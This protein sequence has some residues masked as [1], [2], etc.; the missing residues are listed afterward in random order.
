MG[1]L[2]VLAQGFPG[3][4][5][6]GALAALINTG[7]WRLAFID[8]ELNTLPLEQYVK[9]EFYKN[10]LIAPCRDAMTL[11]DEH[12][13]MKSKGTPKAFRRAYQLV[14]AFEGTDLNGKAQSWGDSRT[15]GPETILGVDG[16]TGMCAAGM[17]RVLYMN[18]KSIRRKQD[19]GMVQSEVVEYT[20]HLITTLP[21]HLY[22]ISHLKINSPRLLEPEDDKGNNPG[23][24]QEIAQALNERAVEVIPT[25]L[26]PNLLGTAEAPNYPG[27]FPVCLYF[28]TDTVH[29]KTSLVIRTV[30]H[31]AVVVKVPGEGLAEKLPVKD[32]LLTIFNALK[33]S[34]GLN[35][36]T[37]RK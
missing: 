37:K 5:K 4:A 26:V 18:G 27:L 19:W 2:R 32:G 17:R 34:G 23:V 15:W 30:P 14:D 31:P 24:T 22:M 25:R 16:L 6:T 20:N 9:P 7:K 1:N 8:F 13:P 12:T 11:L 28:D 21:C 35:G 36:A 3:T 29:G 10:V 33:A